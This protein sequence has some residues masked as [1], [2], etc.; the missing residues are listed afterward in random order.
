MLSCVINRG[1]RT[2]KEW[3]EAYLLGYSCP[4]FDV[5]HS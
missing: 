4:L 2:A 3:R 1:L 5:V